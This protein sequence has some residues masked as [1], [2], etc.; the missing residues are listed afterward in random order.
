M[1]RNFYISL[2]EKVFKETNKRVLGKYTDSYDILT[3][4]KI[5]AAMQSAR[6]YRSAMLTA[7]EFNSDLEL[8]SYA[9]DRKPRWV[10]SRVWGF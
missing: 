9:F 10:K 3:F 6:Y 2:I 4:A 1:L 7:K 5:D 8:L